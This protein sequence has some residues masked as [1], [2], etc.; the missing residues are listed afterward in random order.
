MIK[1]KCDYCGKESTAKPKVN[2]KGIC[3]SKGGILLPEEY[4][5][6]DFCEP[7]CFWLWIILNKPK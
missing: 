1:Y 3:D 4:H 6:K 5:S 2:L 7:E